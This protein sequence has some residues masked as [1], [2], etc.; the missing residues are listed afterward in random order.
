MNWHRKIVTTTLGDNFSLPA[1]NTL[2]SPSYRAHYLCHTTSITCWQ[3]HSTP[4]FNSQSLQTLSRKHLWLSA[5]RGLP[6]YCQVDIWPHSTPPLCGLGSTWCHSLCSNS[7]RGSPHST[8]D[9]FTGAAE[10]CNLKRHLIGHLVRWCWYG[11]KMSGDVGRTAEQIVE[12]AEG[13]LVNMS[14]FSVKILHII[15]AFWQYCTALVHRGYCFYL[16]FVPIL[17]LC[18]DYYDTWWSASLSEQTP[19]HYSLGKRGQGRHWN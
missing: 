8:T 15:P 16:H 5:W 6:I 4:R 3:F 13:R 7:W 19:T 2:H 11:V 14:P 17:Q 1:K 10:V 18:C 9:L 12:C